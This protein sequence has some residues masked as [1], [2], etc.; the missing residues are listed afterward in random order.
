MASTMQ[1]LSGEAE[2]GNGLRGRGKE[3]TSTVTAK[4]SLLRDIYPRQE[5]TVLCMTYRYLHHGY[6]IL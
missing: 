6:K 4:A 1:K 3:N 5:K 2:R